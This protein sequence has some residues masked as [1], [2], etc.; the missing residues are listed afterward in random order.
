MDHVMPLQDIR[1]DISSKYN[2]ISTGI[3]YPF[4]HNAIYANFRRF[5]MFMCICASLRQNPVYEPINNAKQPN[6][7]TRKTAR[8][9]AQVYIWGIEIFFIPWGVSKFLHYIFARIFRRGTGVL[10]NLHYILAKE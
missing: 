5:C 8:N 2:G 9:T 10:K 7:T 6:K 1:P 4:T 3:L